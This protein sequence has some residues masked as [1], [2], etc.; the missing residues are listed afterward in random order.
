MRCDK[1]LLRAKGWHVVSDIELAPKP[2]TRGPKHRPA[3]DPTSTQAFDY[4]DWAAA[5]G[6][7]PSQRRRRKPFLPIIKVPGLPDQIIPAE[8]EAA[9]RGEPAQP[10]R[11]PGRPR[12]E[13][14]RGGPQS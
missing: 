9:L 5:R 11:R 10:R 6:L 4:T 2:R 14:R 7:T 1:F 12:R 8:A 13:T 3:I